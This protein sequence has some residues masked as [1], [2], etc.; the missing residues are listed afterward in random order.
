ME[1]KATG[2]KNWREGLRIHQH[3]VD[4]GEWHHNNVETALAQGQLA[5]LEITPDAF[6]PAEDLFCGSTDYVSG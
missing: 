6:P 4:A 3:D 5:A 2:L 1:S